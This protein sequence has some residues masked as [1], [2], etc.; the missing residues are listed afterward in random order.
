MATTA[1]LED[2]L[3]QPE[4]FP[5]LSVYLDLG[6]QSRA[7]RSFEAVLRKRFSE[8]EELVGEDN[9]DRE[10][11]WQAVHT[12]WDYVHNHLPNSGH[13][14]A[15]F[16]GPRIDLVRAYPVAYRFETKVVLDSRPY[17]RPLAHV[18]EEHEHYLVAEVHSDRASI[19]VLHLRAPKPVSKVAELESEVPGKTAMG[20]WSQR[21]FQWHRRDHIQ[22]HI[23][24]VAEAVEALC[25]LY[26]C[27]GVVLLGQDRTVSDLRKQL[28]K[29]VL[30][31][32]IATAPELGSDDEAALLDRV[33]PLLEAEERFEELSTLLRIVNELGRGGLAAA[34]PEDVTTAALQQRLDI[35][36]LSEDFSTEGWQCSACG[37][38]MA[39]E[40]TDGRCIYCGSET[41]RI[42]LGEALVRLAE[43]QGAEVEIAPPSDEL[44]RLGGVAALLRY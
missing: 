12:V 9:G 41:R 18:V 17:V 15:L 26:N 5:F 34:G 24:K 35:L 2:L 13:G 29:R 23:K 25:D 3:S 44:T 38:L 28:P 42:D 21:R 31:R 19:F 4:S 36:L 40:M 8:L 14:L 11:F 30:E 32:V 33:L 39:T 43:T 20:G 10:A 6:P 37:A 22:R 27:G 7:T 16:V 1:D